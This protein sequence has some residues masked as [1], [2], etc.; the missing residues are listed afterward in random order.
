[1]DHSF[2]LFYASLTDLKSLDSAIT[3]DRVSDQILS[4]VLIER[5]NQKSSDFSPSSRPS[6]SVIARFETNCLMTCLTG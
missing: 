6:I 1:M 2:T 4:R 5:L 3:R